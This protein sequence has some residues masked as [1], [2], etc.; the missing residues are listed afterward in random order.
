MQA[1]LV[2]AVLKIVH[3]SL[4]IWVSSLRIVSL[5]VENKNNPKPV[6]DKAKAQ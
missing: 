6:A 2:G 1:A 4:H 5:D 3:N